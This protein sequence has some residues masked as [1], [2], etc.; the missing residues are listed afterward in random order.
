MQMQQQYP[1]Q[2][3]HMP[4]QMQMPPPTRAPT[5]TC[6]QTFLIVILFLWGFGLFF[7]SIVMMIVG[8]IPICDYT[9]SYGNSSY[10]SNGQGQGR[11]SY[12]YTNSGLIGGGV[13]SF[14][15]AIG[16]ITRASVMVHLRR[17]AANEKALYN[18]KLAMQQKI[19]LSYPQQYA[20]VCS[21]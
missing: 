21:V 15:I 11:T 17:T 1:M 4:I 3:Q 18:E 12:C 16:M 19:Q 8:S 7:G 20:S 10:S 14:L 9:D 5:D 13:G 2:M 6:C